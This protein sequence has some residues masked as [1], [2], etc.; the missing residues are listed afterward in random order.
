MLKCSGMI[1]TINIDITNVAKIFID[2]V[3]EIAMLLIHKS[4]K[5]NSNSN[6]NLANRY[7][8]RAAAILALGKFLVTKNEKIVN[9]TIMKT[10]AEKMNKKVFDHLLKLLSD[11]SRRIK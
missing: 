11:E 7:Y 3:H 10:K 1:I 4:S 9:D 8:V 6:S 2:L 5:F